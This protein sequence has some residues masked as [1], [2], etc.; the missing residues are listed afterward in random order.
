VR[1]W[2]HANKDKG[3][4]VVPSLVL[5]LG[6]TLKKCATIQQGHSI[7]KEDLASG[8]QVAIFRQ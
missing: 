6:T 5:K 2:L 8:E 1:F 4:F 7:E 3:D